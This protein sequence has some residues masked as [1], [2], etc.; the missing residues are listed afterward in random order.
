[1]QS[2]ILAIGA[3]QAF[4]GLLQQE[5]GWTNTFQELDRT[6]RAS[7]RAELAD[8]FFDYRDAINVLKHGE[9]RSYDKLVARR[10]VLPFK[11]KA[12]H[13]A[14]FE[15]GDVSE[16]IRLVEA[17]HVFVRQCSDTIQEIVEALA[18]RRSVPDAGT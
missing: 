10:D 8:R 11:V 9:G 2:A 15:E 13:Q 7:G 1:M 5:K 12:K 18:L 4:E 14:F 3:L 16:G 17:D 6:L